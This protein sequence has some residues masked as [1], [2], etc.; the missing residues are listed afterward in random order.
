M[1]DQADLTTIRDRAF[2]VLHALDWYGSTRESIGAVA[3]CENIVACGWLDGQTINWRPENLAGLV[4]F[5]VTGP[6][7]WFG[8]MSAFP[9]GLKD[10]NS[11]PTKWTRFLGLG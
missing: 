10:T 2:V 9:E 6:Q 3:G 1:F 7:A 4:E 8:R 5:T 11:T